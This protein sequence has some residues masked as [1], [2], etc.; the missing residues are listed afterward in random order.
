MHFSDLLNYSIYQVGEIEITPIKVLLVIFVMGAFWGFF[1]LL[2]GWLKRKTKDEKFS[3]IKWQSLFRMVHLVLFVSG[4]LISLRIL[5]LHPEKVLL[6]RLLDGESMTLAVYH[7]IV[8]I[9][10]VFLSRIIINLIRFYFEKQVQMQKIDRGRSNSMLSISQYLIWFFSLIFIL[11]STGLNLTFFIA[12]SAALLAALG[13]GLQNLFNDFI[14][15]LI[16]LFDRSIQLDDVVEMSDGEVGQVIDISLRVSKILTRDNEVM[17]VPNSKFTSN[18]IINWSHN[19]KN[20]R[21]HV[22]VGVAYGSDVRLVERLLL[23]VADDHS[24]VSTKPSPFVRFNDF[25]ESSLDF[26]LYFWSAES[27]SVEKIKSDLR[28]SIDNAFRKNGVEIPFPQR[29]LHLRSSY[30]QFLKKD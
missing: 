5:G 19:E 10:I 14:S 24:E 23:K 16:I 27:F 4:V 8:F 6:F 11:S 12:S 2:I 25:G 28:F 1:K 17:I 21:F 7:I 15:G 9:S 30:G 29:D 22:N 13:F 20:T 3:G 18:S 26:Q